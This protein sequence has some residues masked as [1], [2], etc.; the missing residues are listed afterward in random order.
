MSIF[1][2]DLCSENDNI[3]ILRLRSQRTWQMKT[4][5]QPALRGQAFFVSVA[6]G[7]TSPRIL[8]AGK[9][10]ACSFYAAKQQ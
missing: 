9:N 1:F 6:G 2:F 10:R 4:T 5:P 7:G 8:L 3:P